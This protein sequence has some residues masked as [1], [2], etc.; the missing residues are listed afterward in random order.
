MMDL[1]KA[2]AAVIIGTFVMIAGPFVA[3]LVVATFQP[4]LAAPALGLGLVIFPVL[5]CYLSVELF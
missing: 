3:A 5:G 4:A 2:Y 1:L